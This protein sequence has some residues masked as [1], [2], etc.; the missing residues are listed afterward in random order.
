M[1]AM[2]KIADEVRANREIANAN[3]AYGALTEGLY[4][5]A[6]TFERAMSGVIGLLKGGGWRLCGAGFDDV[7][8]FVRSLKLD[9]F[10]V[11]A[12]QRQQFAKLVKECEPEVSNRAIASALGVDEGTIRKAGAEKS[13]P[14]GQKAKQNGNAG[15]ENSAP[16]AKDG[17]RDAA[18]IDRRI[19]TIASR[20]AKASPVPA[21]EGK[22]D[23]IVVDLPW[24]M[25][26]IDRDVRPNQAGFDYPTMSEDELLAFGQTVATIAADDCHL[27]L[28]TTAKFLPMALRLIEAWDFRYV[29]PMVWRKAGGFQPVGLPQYNAEFV[30]YARRGSPVFIDTKAFPICFE[31]ARREHSRKPDEFYD[32]IRRATD[33]KRIDMFSREV[34]DGFDQYGDE[35][36][37]FASVEGEKVIAPLRRARPR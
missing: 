27:F 17:R 32:M 23:T 37:R 34:R 36:S 35:T 14:D 29:L 30:I 7:N 8:A 31:G 3:Q 15:A 25:E 24:P 10:K 4:I 5:T 1:T 20:D 33:G 2:A 28:W 18:R 11:V 9:Q 22:Y 12:D 16:S 19:V 13:A 6:F 26:K 21:P